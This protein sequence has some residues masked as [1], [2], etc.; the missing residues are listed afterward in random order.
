MVSQCSLMPGCIGLACGDQRRHM[1]SGSASEALRDN[2]LYNYT[3]NF[4]FWL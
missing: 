3:F 2:E 1:G 4:T